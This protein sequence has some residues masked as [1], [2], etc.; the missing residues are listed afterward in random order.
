MKTD[1]LRLDYKSPY[2]FEAL[3]SWFRFHQIPDLEQID[4]STYS[5]VISTSKGLGWFQVSHDKKRHSLQVT[6]AGAALKDRAK[7]ESGIRRMFDVDADPKLIGKAMNADAGLKSLWARYPGLRVA[8]AWSG[9]ESIITTILG[10]LV[11]VSFGRLLV[12]ELMTGVGA[13]ALHPQTGVPIHLFPTPER[14]ASANLSSVRTSPMRRNAIKT[15]AKVIRDGVFDWQT[16]VDPK[17]LRKTLLSI[18]GIGAWTAEYIAMRGFH[19]DDA[20]PSTDYGLKQE[21]V[22]RPKVQ[23]DRVRPWRAYA[24]ASLWR[25]YG[26]AKRQAR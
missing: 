22:R 12:C 5:R 3:L 6:L 8:R 7:L 15:V 10:Q 11:S 4:D 25:S 16:P 14:L 23:V 9:Y 19:D 17:A 18:P 13:K 21:L 20:F 24:A 26:D 1:Q 2:D